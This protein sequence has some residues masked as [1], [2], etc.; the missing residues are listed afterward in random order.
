M[1]ATTAIGARLLQTL[2]VL[3]A[4]VTILF[5]LF[6]LMPGSPLAAYIDPNFTPEQ[7]D[8]LMARF[9]LDKPLWQQYF[10]YL[11]NLL[12]GDLGESFFY[13]TPV[14]ERVLALLP[15]TL[16]LTFSSLIVAYAFGVLAGAYLAWKRG[17][18]VEQIGIPLVLT[19]RAMPE[20]WLGM[21]LLAVFSFGMGWFPAGGTRPPGAEYD[22]YWAL[23]TSAD[24]WWH[25]TLPVLT[26]AIYSQG[27]PLLLMRSNML[28]VMRE[29]FVTMARIKGLSP[30]TVVIRHAARNALLPVMTSFAIAVGYQIQ[31]NVVVETVFSWPG[32]GRE[33]VRAVSAS[34][35]PLA[36]GAFLM[37]AVVVILM[38]LIADLLYAA[39][40]PRV[41]RE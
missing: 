1:K 14:A 4:V 11:G 27:L 32:L 26:L 39:L 28:D 34:D 25:M 15:N 3:W 36:Q 23:Y 24:F 37:I 20:F 19:T 35:Y 13:R 9:G 6:R 8:A 31:G 33:L 18:A 38:N 17:G 22:G 10:I 12:Q 5:F 41:T 40:D 21:L 29:D 2:F 16:I 30:F 7:Q